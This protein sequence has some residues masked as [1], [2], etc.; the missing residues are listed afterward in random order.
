LPAHTSILTGRLPFETSVRDN[1]GFTVKPGE[2]LLPQMLRE[3]GFA[4]AGI[5][6]TYVLRKETGISQGFDFYDSNLPMQAQGTS[7]GD[8]QRDG[9]ETLKVGDS[10]LDSR[11][12]SRFFLFMHFYEPHKP[13]TPPARFGRYAPYDGEIAYADELVGRL[14]DSLKRRHLYDS[15]AI[16]LLSDHGEGLGD[17]VEQEHGLFIYEETLHVPLIIK[18]P[19]SA[20]RGRRVA[21]PVQ[22]I[23]VVPTVL[24]LAG[25]P[26]PGGLQ[27]RSLLSVM[28][29]T[30]QL[31]DQGIYS[32]SL[33][34]R[35]HFGWSELYAL[36]DARLRYIKAPRDELY[37]LARDPAERQNLA[38][39]QPQAR[40]AMRR[41]LDGMVRSA[42]VPAPAGVSADD[43][44]RLQSLGYV[45]TSASLDP[46]AGGDL[47]DPKD[48]I[49]VLEAYRH[50]AELAGERKYGPAIDV[51]Q[52]IVDENPG[53]ADVWQQ[54]GNLLVRAG[55]LDDGVRA[56][57]RS[58]ELTPRDTSALVAASTVL[59][60]LRRLDEAKRDGERALAGAVDDQPRSRG[61][62]EEVLAKIALAR[63]DSEAARR[64]AA[65]AESADPSVPIGSYVEGLILY[66]SERYED[67]VRQFR[68][69]EERMK[70]VT[71]QLTELHYYCG[72]ALAR[73]ERYQDAESEFEQE[74]RLF[75]Q[76]GRAWAALAVVYH[77]EGRDEKASAALDD[78]THAMPTPEGYALAAQAWTIFGDSRRAD[79]LRAEARQKF[80]GD[81]TLKLLNTAQPSQ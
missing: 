49:D 80:K 20:G 52:H 4:T 27:G 45:G 9:A 14:L 44:K 19:Q 25:L 64:H 72:D 5:V 43:R 78:L 16:V 28:R 17:H 15:A 62:A 69:T 63:K 66:D 26:R 8:V 30:S 21:A 35:Y 77:T 65:N 81:P 50:A 36:T 58:A 73:L 6:S 22:H 33:Y 29:G 46:P 54:L 10:W 18:L 59:F 68:V 42:S 60:K 70:S 23:D 56:Y 67:A 7:L 74:V 24:D 57:E 71:L 40:V 11:P 3:Q 75:P 32:E 34:G 79:A 2:R 12:S 41:A 48:K 31:A 13:Y 51:L 39:E 76:N 38:I 47:V 61:A 37:D 53:M 1:I 55:R